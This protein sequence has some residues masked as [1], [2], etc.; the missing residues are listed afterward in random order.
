MKKTKKQK[1]IN[2]ARQNNGARANNL[3]QIIFPELEE[4]GPLLPNSRIGLG[5][6]VNITNP[7][8]GQLS[9]G[10]VT[11]KTKHFLWVET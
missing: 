3:V 10:I 4:N 9:E 1:R 6:R 7:T 2:Q 11:H 8:P 5:D